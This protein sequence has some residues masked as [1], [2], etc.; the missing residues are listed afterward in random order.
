MFHP[1]KIKFRRLSEQ[2]KERYF[3]GKYHGIIDEKHS[4]DALKEMM[5]KRKS[6]RP[7]EGSACHL[8]STIQSN[9]GDLSK[10]LR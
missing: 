3:S 8:M 1:A 2:T 6:G 7:V 10:L 9:Y 4:K 5:A